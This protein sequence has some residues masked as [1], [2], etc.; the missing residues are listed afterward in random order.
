MLSASQFTGTLQLLEQV[1]HHVDA[2]R[3]GVRRLGVG[4]VPGRRIGR[5][6][7]H[8]TLAVGAHVPSRRNRFSYRGSAPCWSGFYRWREAP[9]LLREV[10]HDH[11]LG[12]RVGRDRLGRPEEQEAPVR[13]DVELL[14]FARKKVYGLTSSTPSGDPGSNAPVAATGTVMSR[15]AAWST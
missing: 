2:R 5:L 15:C 7:E 3:H 13:A 8:E 11:D 14:W 12:S 10:E 4:S 9:Q 6:D 1:D